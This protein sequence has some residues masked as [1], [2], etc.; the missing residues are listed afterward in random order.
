ME[1]VRLDHA[2]KRATIRRLRRPGA[3]L[4]AAVGTPGPRRSNGLSNYSILKAADGL[5]GILQSID[6]G[7]EPKYNKFYIGLAKHGSPNNF[8]SSRGNVWDGARSGC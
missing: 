1:R 2:D 8:Q 3:P 4:E 7:L 5:L 6:E